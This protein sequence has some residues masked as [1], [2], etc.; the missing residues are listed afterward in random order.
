MRAVET[1]NALGATWAGAMTRSLVD[2]SV[3][4]AVV[5][6]VWFPLRR[7][8]S[9]QMAYGL[10]LL[11]LVKAAVP[12]PVELPA[13]VDRLLSPTEG[14][15]LVVLP[16][17]QS[18]RT[19]ATLHPD[20]PGH[21]DTSGVDGPDDSVPAVTPSS[22]DAIPPVPSSPR[23]TPA[24]S[25]AR[26]GSPTL[27]IYAVMMLVW[28]ALTGALLVR[29]SCVHI[30]MHMRLRDARALEPGTLA[31]DYGLLCKRCGLARPVPLLVTP[32]VSSPAVW[33]LLRPRV[34]VP[35]GLAESLPT[36]QLTWVLLH[37]LIHVRR[38]DAWVASFQRLV[39]I[40][41]VFHPVVFVANRLIDL[42]R[43]YACDDAAIALA[44]EVPRR[45]CAAGFLAVIERA[46]ARPAGASPALG[47][48]GSHTFL[49]RR[50]MRILD[51]QRSTRRRISVRGALALG[52]LAVMVLPYVRAREQDKP[53]P[54]EP[55]PVASTSDS[56]RAG[57]PATAVKTEAS[58][59]P[60]SAREVEVRVVRKEDGQPLAGATVE[61]R[62]YREGYTNR[63]ASTD[64]NG[65]CRIALPVANPDFTI[66]G[67]VKD[68]FIPLSAS[69]REGDV[70]DGAMPPY[71]IEMIRGTTIGL[72]V[73]DEQGKPIAG[74]KVVP[75]FM[76]KIGGSEKER[77]HTSES[78]ASLTDAQG[79][80]R[81]DVLPAKTGPKD[82]LWFR[83]VHPDFV[84][85]R[86][87][88]S[89]TLTIE[90]A[91]AGKGVLVMKVGVPIAGR[92][93]GPAGRP[94]AG[95]AVALGY[96][97]SDGD[98]YRTR[99]DADGRF[100]FAHIDPADR[101]NLNL[102]VEA[103]GYAP[104][105]KSLLSASNL[106]SQEFQL[107]A[108]KPFRGRVVDTAGK[109]L[110]GALVKLE[111][112]GG[113]R[114]WTW[115]SETDG[116][117]RFDWPD[118]PAAGDVGFNVSKQPF[119][120]AMGRRLAVG[121]DDPIIS[122]HQPLRLRGK[123]VD[124]Q[125]GKPIEAFVLIAGWGPD[126]PGGQISWRR[127]SSAKKRIGGT[128]DEVGLFPDQ[129]LTRSLRVEAEG[130]APG[131]LI[132]FKDDAGEIVHDFK[133]QRA[134]GLSGVVRGLHGKPL[135]GAVVALTNR[136]LRPR[137]SNVNLDEFSRTLGVTAETGPD[138]RYEFGSQ[139]EPSG[140]IVVANE[141]FARRSPEQLAASTTVRVDPWGRVE[142]TC[143]IGTRPLLHQKIRLSVDATAESSTDYEFYEYEAETD[144]QGRFVVERVIPGDARA[145][146]ATINDTIQGSSTSMGS[147]PIEI[148]PGETAKVT[149]GGQG[150]PVIGRLK[151]PDGNVLPLD[152]AG[153]RGKLSVKIDQPKMPLPEDFSTWDRERR[154][155]Y[156]L[157]WYK[158]PQARASRRA[159][160]GNGLKI[161]SDGS[162]RA[163]EVL[164]GSYE[165][166]VSAGGDE[167]ASRNA[168][169]TVIRATARRDVVVPEIPGGHTDQP[170]D[171]GAIKL[172]VDVTRYKALEVG[173][174]APEFATKAL[175]GKPLS[176]ADFRGRYV[177]LDFWATWCIPCLEQEPSL[178]SAYD[179]FGKDPRFAMVSLSLDEGIE[180]P[181]AYLAKREL[182]WTQGFLGA[183]ST[184]RVPADY[185][186]RGIP[187]I[188]L[189]GPDGRVLAKDLRGDAIKTAVAEALRRK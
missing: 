49:R 118:G 78:G 25:M 95:A 60:Q 47:L 151:V 33:G 14:R 172:A 120:R 110:P 168:E 126:R 20:P 136:S 59:K 153:G 87:G 140:I 152:L 101:S 103:A 109:P 164:P 185:G 105:V 135:A 127:G 92:V 97:N 51:S 142:G 100:R 5:L 184:T 26:P 63:L 1:L 56:A 39:Q 50:M 134:S 10:F 9:S 94:V 108:A 158:S 81:A 42:Q 157:N 163:E 15:P 176:L 18:Q 31:V 46:C 141:G 119:T 73:Q 122:L 174:P 27:S 169:G 2:A 187:S 37:E 34:L 106:P 167:L 70:K 128:Y 148:K 76:G 132:G 149:I 156:S 6:L 52:I 44:G 13:A 84:S 104:A 23:P 77:F 173:Q 96:S 74:A 68:G 83:L 111:N 123:V 79:R 188:W 162:F 57:A 114:H 102:G 178:K 67:A 62:F 147:G 8:I 150:R 144:Q 143:R 165:L 71:T 4:L 22:T 180:A 53:A 88:F 86:G 130:Y 54:T 124:S 171:L 64:A 112:F 85:E 93:V 155:A 43:E 99:T 117:G 12:V 38:R 19:H 183:W 131:V 166:T 11:V 40:V 75:W 159:M 35:P 160:P 16:P 146:T 66:L 186:V 125:T 3:V 154:R 45:D 58:I 24:D 138:G 21:F 115:M 41:Y 55:A 181:R 170:L 17:R 29:F 129:G 161:E 65:R 69:W 28:A 48:F 80:W 177:L 98:C 61:A 179:A 189:I 116:D 145:T 175:D 113:S 32:W 36:G 90:E 107:E 133:L 7:R 82:Q 72:Q 182:R 91:R 89:R 121:S 137:I 30:R 139:D